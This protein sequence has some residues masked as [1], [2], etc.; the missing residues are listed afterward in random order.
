M[1]KKCASCKRGGTDIEAD[2]LVKGKVWINNE[3]MMP[4]RAYLCEEHLDMMEDD[5]A[6][7]EIVEFV[8]R[9]KK[10]ERFT[11]LIR[12]YTGYK[13]INEILTNNPTL[14]STKYCSKK[15]KREISELRRYYKEFSGETA[16]K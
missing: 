11:K 9:T 2:Y 13:S 1:I 10:E 5:D 3:R 14:R 4:Y 12:Y 15:S 7:L 6:E 8:S 16:S